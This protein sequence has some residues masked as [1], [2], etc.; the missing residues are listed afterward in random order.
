M[1]VEPPLIKGGIGDKAPE[2][3][4][5]CISGHSPHPKSQFSPTVLLDCWGKGKGT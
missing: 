2:L 3:K 4:E 5:L 1:G